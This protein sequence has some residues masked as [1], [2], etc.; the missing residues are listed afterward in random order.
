[1]RYIIPIVIVGM[2]AG[3][4]LQDHAQPPRHAQFVQV[5]PDYASTFRSM[6][7]TKA[8]TA[9]DRAFIE[10]YRGWAPTEAAWA[11]R[12]LDDVDAR[13]LAIEEQAVRH[14][15]SD[16]ASLQ[17]LIDRYH[18]AAEEFRAAAKRR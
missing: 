8:R 6:E 3:L 14:E 17:A 10:T 11:L 18:E 9:K 15:G 12:L 2:G 4:Y 7:A 5:E 13:I 1:M 16:L